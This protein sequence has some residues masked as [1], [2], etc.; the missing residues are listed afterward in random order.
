MVQHTAYGLFIVL[1]T[2][3]FFFNLEVASFFFF[4]SF[5]KL[6]YFM[7]DHERG[8]GT[9]RGRETIPSRLHTVSTELDAGLELMNP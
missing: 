3:E 1:V 6:I 5:V 4:F 2:G 8:Q 7:R 9:E